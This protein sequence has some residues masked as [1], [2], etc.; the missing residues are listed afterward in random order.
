VFVRIT[1]KLFEACHQTKWFEMFRFAQHASVAPAKKAWNDYSVYC[2]DWLVMYTGLPESVVTV[3]GANG[4][5]NDGD[6]ILHD[7]FAGNLTFRCAPVGC[8]FVDWTI[9]LLSQLC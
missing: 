1:F 2:I 8:C 6:G 9:R 7:Q 5:E 4:E 3:V